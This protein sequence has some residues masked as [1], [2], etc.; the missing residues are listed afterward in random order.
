MAQ[1]RWIAVSALLALVSP[2]VPSALAQQ[3]QQDQAQ[4]QQQ[5]QERRTAGI[6][7]ITVTAQ[8]R[9]QLLQE[10]PVAVTAFS[11]DELESLS[12]DSSQDIAAFT[13]GLVTSKASNSAG[14][15]ALF[16]R[17]VGNAD[18][19]PMVDT[20]VGLY[21]DGAYASNGN[22]AMFDLLDVERIEVLRGPQG[23]LYGRN[24]IGGAI[25]IISKKPTNEFGF[26]LKGTVGEHNQR[27][28]RGTVN[29][30][31]VPETVL[32]RFSF[33][34]GLRDGFYRNLHSRGGD[35]DDKDVKGFR[36][37]LRVIPLES[38]TMDYTFDWL[39]R[40]EHTPLFALRTDCASGCRTNVTGGLSTG[41][42]IAFTNPNGRYGS[43]KT[44]DNDDIFNDEDRFARVKSWN[45][46]INIAWGSATTSRSS[47]S[48]VGGAGC[49][50]VPTTSMAHRSTSST[51]GS[52]SSRATSYRS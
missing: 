17:G 37:A 1:L 2:L 42:L 51:Q 28:F 12:I 49:S 43:F 27:E 52:T 5:T 10:T 11:A 29:V 44:N 8:R 4:Q 25:N 35:F 22:S 46:A 20:K 41:Q 14:L 40:D 13:P 33:T 38:V 6:E 7:A 45:H 30:P 19:H 31:I 48:L 39:E 50:A 26:K 36:S 34:R 21:I 47:R 32:A 16:G 23:T 18:N 3:P 24:T 15:M 9:E